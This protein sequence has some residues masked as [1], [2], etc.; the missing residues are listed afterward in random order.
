MGGMAASCFSTA[1]THDIDNDGEEE[2]KVKPELKLDQDS[3][4]KASSRTG[5]R[6]V[7]P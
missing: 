3:G 2:E 6:G 4:G 1:H 7:G 5:Y